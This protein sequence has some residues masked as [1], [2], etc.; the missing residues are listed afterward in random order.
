MFAII[1]HIAGWALGLVESA[2]YA[3]LFVTMGL[4]SFAIPIPSEVVVP[5]GGFLAAS[6]VFNFGLVVTFVTL[7]NLTGSVTLFIIGRKWGSVFLRKYGKYLLIHSNEIDKMDRWLERHGRKTAFFSRLLPGVRT[8][9]S[10]VIGAGEVKFRI[11]FWYTLI[12]SFLWNL[13]WAYLGFAAGEN[14]NKFQPLVRKF[15]YLIVALI[16][17]FVVYFVYKH[18][19]GKH[20]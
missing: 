17:V 1:E 11:F 15:D 10:L 8:F 9:S 6:G 7:G 14:W 18:L 16:V 4:E 19:K 2:G 20:V 5:F 3:G 13:L 12:G